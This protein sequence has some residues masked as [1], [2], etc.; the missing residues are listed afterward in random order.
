MSNS[1][2][3]SPSIEGSDERQRTSIGH[4]QTRNPSQR[5]RRH[6]YRHG[7][8]RGR[9][10]AAAQASL[11][12]GLTNSANIDA[13]GYNP[14]ATS[15]TQAL[16]VTGKFAYGEWTDFSIGNGLTLQVNTG[17]GVSPNWVMVNRVLA[18]GL[19][20]NIAGTL[21]GSGNIWIINPNGV[22]FANGSVVDVGG[23]LVSTASTFDRTAFLASN[24]APGA[25]NSFDFLDA[26]VAG[27]GGAGTTADIL[28]A[29]LVTNRNGPVI[30]HA[31]K[32]EVDGTIA[33]GGPGDFVA[34][35]AQG[36]SLSLTDNGTY[37]QIDGVTAVGGASALSDGTA[38]QR[39]G[40]RCRQGGGLDHLM[41]FAVG[42]S[43]PSRIV[44]SGSLIATAV[45]T[46]GQN[47]VLM[48]PDSPAAADAAKT[49]LVTGG[50]LQP[51][52]TGT[53]GDITVNFASL[54]TPAAGD[55]AAAANAGLWIQS[56]GDVQIGSVKNPA[57]DVRVETSAHNITYFGGAGGV[58]GAVEGRDIALLAP[59]GG[60]DTGT[61]VARDDVVARA[62]THV[63][64]LDVTTG[65]TS[66]GT[67]AS[68]SDDASTAADT[69][70]AT[71]PIAF[72]DRGGFSLTGGANGHQVG[73]EVTVGAVSAPGEVR[74]LATTDALTTGS[75]LAT[76]DIRV[77]ATLGSVSTAAITEKTAGLSVRGWAGG[78]MTLT[79]GISAPGH[80]LLSAGD[81]ITETGAI[82]GQDVNITATRSASAAAGS[83]AGT[84]SVAAIS[85]SGDIVINAGDA[86]VGS[87]NL[88]STAGSVTLAAGSTAS[89]DG[90]IIKATGAPAGAMD[91]SAQGAVS[92]VAKGA[93][94]VGN[95]VA[96]QG[97]Q[98]TSAR[99]LTTGDVSAGTDVIL[100][101]NPTTA[102][103]GSA[104]IPAG[105]SS[106]ATGNITAVHD[107]TLTASSGS[108]TA[109]SGTL[110]G[111]L[112]ADHAV[113]LNASQDISVGAIAQKT[114]TALAPTVAISAGGS[115]TTGDVAVTGDLLVKASGAVTLGNVTASGDITAT[116]GSGAI[117][118][119]NLASKGDIALQTTAG[120]VTT[121][122]LTAP[123]DIVIR[124]A[125]AIK[126]N[127]LTTSGAA[128]TT[129]N[130][131]DAVAAKA[132]IQSFWGSTVK[133]YDVVAGSNI[134]IKGGGAVTVG[135][136]TVNGA[137]SAIRI[138]GAG[139]VTL[140]GAKL[141]NAQ[142][143]DSVLL[144][145]SDFASPATPGAINAGAGDLILGFTGAATLG[146]A[147]GAG[148]FD[149]TEV[150]G[151]TANSLAV[152]AGGSPTA[153]SNV[154]VGNLA[155]TSA[156]RTI[157]VYSGSGSRVDI[158]GAVTDPAG[159]SAAAFNV[160]A[161]DTPLTLGTVDLPSAG[162]PFQT[163]K[164]GGVNL[165]SAW[166]PGVIRVSGTIGESGTA[167]GTVR[168]SGAQI[169]ISPAAADDPTAPAG[170]FEAFASN[171][172]TQLGQLGGPNYTG[173][174]KE[175][176]K[177]GT[178][179]LRAA[180][181]I[182]ERNLDPAG[183]IANA[184]G[185][186]ATNLVVQRLSSTSTALPSRVNLYGQ[187][188][189]GG[190][191]IGGESAALSLT[192]SPT[193]TATVQF[194]VPTA[195]ASGYRINN[196]VIGGGGCFVTPP[197]A[198]L[199]PIPK[200]DDIGTV[201]DPYTPV[202]EEPSD[203]SGRRGGM[204]F[205]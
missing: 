181:G 172:S 125:G 63:V 27:S 31:P 65:V 41:I 18:G 70:A 102:L 113:T 158:S 24:A 39:D 166:A 198:T 190:K 16:T 67:T 10:P 11:L 91:I 88:S 46:D 76:G 69:V 168:L 12:T 159:G 1:P 52:P 162:T 146:G 104:A 142:A 133:S 117:S 29:G 160:G 205:S 77:Q 8:R 130:P 127:D 120:S 112:K 5:R 201:S 53:G 105:S 56:G 122:T 25:T 174:V 49:A 187:V 138:S 98:M 123:D 184:Q 37:Y 9:G 186:S 79:G 192:D 61:L 137:G 135:S 97:V 34:I 202:D 42:A 119:G 139:L 90:S 64:T 2:K 173:G 199:P 124:A 154:T 13:S 7:P 114:A 86:I 92:V 3:S 83:S 118:A 51:G 126:T 26:G 28:V 167:I 4:R 95:V 36:V 59:K 6:R 100:T 93:V 108:V 103:A 78:A 50:V 21:T 136:A 47:I 107:V 55:P 176:I 182:F 165:A 132:P 140:T 85:T 111:A 143:G 116:Q 144:I 195:T 161:F 58:A 128:A 110:G 73:R 81:S 150:G 38:A 149:N 45:R 153:S 22:T 170:G 23:L 75:I 171:P 32:V 129:S 94:G 109:K 188:S 44:A 43:A 19:R 54:N 14:T 185:F 155:F 177:V 115:A 57:G 68:T 131:A 180:T 74:L 196:C 175:Q 30:L 179:E 33:H 20:S 17:T 151:V 189:Q 66:A 89:A 72:V 156:L 101:A 96:S 204:A 71:D 84:V 80:V 99:G 134:D 178:L 15:G 203:R 191:L 106:I 141:S 82:T 48:T 194:G 164:F 169:F 121:G 157:N 40:G 152:F 62:L 35:S 147:A 200:P 193:G 60:I 148:A 163:P 87:G 145:G 197:P 183:S